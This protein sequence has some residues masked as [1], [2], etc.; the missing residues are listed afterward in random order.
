M[1]DIKCSDPNHPAR[2]AAPG[3]ND[4]ILARGSKPIGGIICPGC[5]RQSDADERARPPRKTLE[6]RVAALEAAI[7]GR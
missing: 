6:E 5:A 7:R 2:S 4:G 1:A 3:W